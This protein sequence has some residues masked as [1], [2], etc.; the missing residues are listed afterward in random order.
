MDA[1]APAHAPDRYPL[2][3]SL[4]L[5]CVADRLRPD[6]A[7]AEHE[8]V[9]PVLYRG[10]GG[11]RGPLQEEQVTL[12][13]LGFQVPGRVRYFGEQPRERRPDPLLAAQDPCRGDEDGVV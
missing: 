2:R 4:A 13:D 11:V 9:D 5:Q 7:V 10:G 8:G 12:V 3:L 1:F 6:K